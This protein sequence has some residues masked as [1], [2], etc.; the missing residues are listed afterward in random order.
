MIVQFYADSLGLARPGYVKL[1]ERYIYLFQKWLQ[2]KYKEE[3]FLADRARGAHTVEALFKW[4]EEDEGYFAGTKD[5]L[6]IQEG[7]VDCAPRPIPLWFRNMVSVMPHP[8]KFRIIRFLHNKRAFLLKNGFRHFLVS[9]EKFGA[10]YRTWLQKASKDFKRIY[11]F[12]IA[13]TTAEIETHSPGLTESINAYNAI[14][15]DIAA[16]GH[17]PNL[18]LINIHDLLKQTPSIEDYILED[19]HH[20]TALA[21]RIYAQQLIEHEQ[22][23]ID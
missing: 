17:I 19:G 8:I 10:C 15:T 7:I 3:V 9:K 13:P 11:V 14:L 20:I 18:T 4:F 12:N 23:I 1:D 2:D 16:S 6:I 22:R 21:H 5:I